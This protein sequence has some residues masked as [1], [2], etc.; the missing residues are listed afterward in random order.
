MYIIILKQKILFKK[1]NC[2]QKKF[3][4]LGMGCVCPADTSAE[5]EVS[6]GSTGEKGITPL[7]SGKGVLPE[8]AI[9]DLCGFLCRGFERANNL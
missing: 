8:K 4:F 1:I 7:F 3:D 6:D 5:R 9:I 2:R